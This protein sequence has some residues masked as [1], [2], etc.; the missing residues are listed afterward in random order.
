VNYVFRNKLTL[1][2]QFIDMENSKLILLLKS[3]VGNNRRNKRLL[4][5]LQSPYFNKKDEVVQLYLQ[6]LNYAPDF[7]HPEMTKEN[8]FARVSNLPQYDEKE[9]GYL[10][11]DLVKLI[12]EFIIVE[13]NRNNEVER[14]EEL[15]TYYA[16]NR[17]EKLHTN[18]LKSYQKFID[19]FPHRDAEYYRY[20]F[21]LHQRENEFFDKQKRHEGNDSLQKAID[22]LDLYYIA[23]KLKYSCEMLNRRRMVTSDY[24]LRL[25]NEIVQYLA[26]HP[27]DNIPPVAVYSCILNSFLNTH[28]DY[29]QT[30]KQ[31]L[32]NY[33]HLFP[34]EEARDLY[35][36]ALNYCIER[37]NSGDA[38]YAKQLFELY[39][40]LLDKQIIFD[41]GYL[42]PWTYINIVATGVRVGEYSWTEEFIRH[43][44]TN[45]RTQF[46][47]NAYT[48]NLGYLYFYR[49]EYHRT[50]QLLNEV[51]FDDMFYALNSKVLIMAAYYELKETDAL[52][53]L[54]ASFKMYLRR[55]KLISD[56]K[57]ERFLNYIRFVE[58]LT[59]I[60]QGNK[61]ATQQLDSLAEKMKA[62]PNTVNIKWLMEKVAEKQYRS[63]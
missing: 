5:F 42:S 60:W 19:E 61:N 22:N 30:L 40:I 29:Y 55:S 16:S 35:T 38:S 11:S 8:L 59:K 24:Q 48:Y 52:D 26:Q 25:V 57:T 34:P 6:L 27:N 7:E 58:Q 17:I 28:A 1:V 31:L 14:Y 41:N 9:F 43:Y 36:F 18:T 32:D 3:I 54:I 21:L 2:P 53:S 47:E 50:L 45:L 4:D 13:Q 44:K 20:R 62:T 56:I 23:N 49:K 39:Q 33:A 10:M 15:I 46:R 51:V 37:I 12:E 63:Q